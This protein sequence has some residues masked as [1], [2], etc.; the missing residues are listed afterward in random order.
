MN[1]PDFLKN[2]N[3]ELQ[4]KWLT[5]VSTLDEYSA[6]MWLLDHLHEQALI[7]ESTAVKSVEIIKFDAVMDDQELI[8]QTD[9][10]DEFVDFV[11]ADSNSPSND[12]RVFANELL[13][14]WANQINTQGLEIVGDIDHAEYDRIVQSGVSVSKA[15]ELIK[16]TKKGIAKSV[17]AFVEKGKL[18]V[19]A[20]IDK[21]YKKV[22]KAANGV[23][24]EALADKNPLTGVYDQGSLLGFTFAVN[25]RRQHD[26][27]V[28]L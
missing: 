3:K 25:H 2:K 4:S 15:A 28:I 26:S 13:I 6:N 19:R 17:K 11:L 24:L 16:Q 14:D 23:S 8:I 7:A 22:I 1:I 18:F 5:L 27:A 21:R 12:Q 10:V 20:I 9:G